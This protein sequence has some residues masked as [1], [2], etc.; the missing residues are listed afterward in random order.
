MADEIQASVNITEQ[1]KAPSGSY[2]SYKNG[3][4]V[5]Q[6]ETTA[7]QAKYTMKQGN[8]TKLLADCHNQRSQR[9]FGYLGPFTRRGHVPESSMAKFEARMLLLSVFCNFVFLILLGNQWTREYRF[10]SSSGACSSRN[11][12]NTGNSRTPYG[13]RGQQTPTM[14]N[15]ARAEE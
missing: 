11:S 12:A 9:V 13:K 2:L 5:P 10:D 6:P 14:K 3:T 15:R 1:V 8:Q 7:W 4:Q